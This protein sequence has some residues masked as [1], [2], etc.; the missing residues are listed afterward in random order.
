[1]TERAI[2]E[3]T[4]RKAW[5]LHTAARAPLADLPSAL[6]GV[7][8]GATAADRELAV[9]RLANDARAADLGRAL[10]ALNADARQLE[11][12]L[13]TLRRPQRRFRIGRAALAVAAM[14]ALAAVIALPQWRGGAAS[15]ALPTAEPPAMIT[16]S[17]FET[18]PAAAPGDADTLFRAGFDS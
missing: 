6:Q 8:D 17:S 11:S 15:P 13:L 4:L 9:E 14:L 7:E 18:V 3:A 1:M 12:D 5:R 2:N 10:L 16:A